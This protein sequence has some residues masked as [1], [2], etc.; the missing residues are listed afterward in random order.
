MTDAGLK[1]IGKHCKFIT[2]LALYNNEKITIEGVESIINGKKK[3]FTNKI[4]TFSIGTKTCLRNLDVTN[5]EPKDEFFKILGDKHPEILRISL[6][7]ATNITDKGIEYLIERC[8]F[9]LV[10]QLGS[11]KITENVRNKTL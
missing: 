8:N 5:V 3:F 9:I 4:Y 7:P 11:I 6:T 2:N 1:V 10:L